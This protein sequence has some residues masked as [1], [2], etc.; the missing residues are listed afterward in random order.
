MSE[1]PDTPINGPASLAEETN[2]SK[3]TVLYGPLLDSENG[4]SPI[5]SYD[6][7]IDIG[8]GSNFR[9]LIGGDELGNSLETS[10]LVQ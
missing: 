7:Q 9:S 2:E 5:L 4:G 6:L 1:V 10:Y 8:D 3:I